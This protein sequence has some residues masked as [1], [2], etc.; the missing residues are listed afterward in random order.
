MELTMR[1][2]SSSK[3]IKVSGLHIVSENFAT[4]NVQNDIVQRMTEP[5]TASDLT[6]SAQDVQ[7]LRPEMAQIKEQIVRVI[8]FPLC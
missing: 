2:A 6:L 8:N 3:Q 1:S 7:I 4:N 5:V